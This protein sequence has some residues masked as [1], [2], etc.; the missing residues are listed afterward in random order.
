VTTNAP[1]LH[2]PAFLADPHA[3]FHQLRA[4][5]PVQ[6]NAQLGAWLVLGHAAVEEGLRHPALSADA[7]PAYMRRLPAE[8]RAALR[9][10]EDFFRA[11]MVFSDPPG[12]QR[13]R[14]AFSSDFS[15]RAVRRHL[16]QLQEA[17][18]QSE[19]ELSTW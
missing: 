3:R 14:R 4:G 15:A 6:F 5:Q 13:V 16:P 18:G 2:D 10:L 12:Q 7:V 9:Q 1:D 8:E 11:W 17:A 19:R